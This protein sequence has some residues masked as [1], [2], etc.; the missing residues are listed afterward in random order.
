MTY[1]YFELPD[2]ET[3][4]LYAGL[5]HGISRPQEL[6]PDDATQYGFGRYTRDGFTTYCIEINGED[7]PVHAQTKLNIESGILDSTFSE[8]YQNEAEEASMKAL[9]LASERVKSIDL[10]PSRFTAAEVVVGSPEEFRAL[11]WKPLT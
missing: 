8:V 1:R 5:F 2:L 6:Y 10:L 4:T 11:G 7:S 3:A 9:I